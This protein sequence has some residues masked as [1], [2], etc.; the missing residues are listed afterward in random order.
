MDGACPHHAIT[1]DESGALVSR[2][3]SLH[4]DLSCASLTVQVCRKCGI[5]MDASNLDHGPRFA[6]GGHLWQQSARKTKSQELAMKQIAKICTN[7]NLGPMEKEQVRTLA[8]PLISAGGKSI[9]PRGRGSQSARELGITRERP[10]RRHPPVQ[11]S[12]CP[13]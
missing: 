1:S 2:F 3:I 13:V 6:L 5:V 8:M 10:R 4:P 11:H 7:I 12:C 9:Y